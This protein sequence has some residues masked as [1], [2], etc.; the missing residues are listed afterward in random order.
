[1]SSIPKRLTPREIKLL[2]QQ[3]RRNSFS[4]SGSASLLGNEGMKYATNKRSSLCAAK[5]DAST[6]GE[7]MLENEENIDP[8]NSLAGF[9]DENRRKKPRVDSNNKAKSVFGVRN[10]ARASVGSSNAS[11]KGKTASLAPA[12]GNNKKRKTWHNPLQNNGCESG[13]GNSVGGGIKTRSKSTHDGKM[14]KIGD[15]F[16]A[17]NSAVTGVSAT[18][19]TAYTNAEPDIGLVVENDESQISESQSEKKKK[20]I[21][22]EDDDEEDEEFVSNSDTES[23]CFGLDSNA[24]RDSQVATCSRALVRHLSNLSSLSQKAPFETSSLVE[25]VLANNSNKNA[26]GATIGSE[27]RRYDDIDT[28][29]TKRKKEEGSDDESY[30]TFEDID[31][32][33]YDWGFKSTARF[34]S[35]DSFN[36]CSNIKS[37]FKAQAVQDKVKHMTSWEEAS[38]DDK[39]KLFYQSMMCWG[40]S[41]DDEALMYSALHDGIKK[42]NKG[43]S[44]TKYVSKSATLVSNICEDHYFTAITSAYDLFKNGKISHF[45]V[46]S[47]YFTTLFISDETGA[48]DGYYAI[49]NSSSKGL[50]T[51]LNKEEISY[52]LPLLKPVEAS[53][54]ENAVDDELTDEERAL[55]HLEARFEKSRQMSHE[56]ALLFEGLEEVHGLFDFMLNRNYLAAVRSGRYKKSQNGSSHNGTFFCPDFPNIYCPAPFVNGSLRSLNIKYNGSVK[57]SKGGKGL[58]QTNIFEINGP[59]LFSSLKA[60]LKIFAISQPSGFEV[61]LK[62]EKDLINSHLD[63]SQSHTIANRENKSRQV[64]KQ[65]S[66]ISGVIDRLQAFSL[67][68]KKLRIANHDNVILDNDDDDSLLPPMPGSPD[69]LSHTSNRSQRPLAQSDAAKPKT[70]LTQIK[71]S[72]GTFRCKYL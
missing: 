28:S 56:T 47:N 26:L 53:K 20:R 58:D 40:Y 25:D 1:M 60:L 31:D 37:S 54:D 51:L 43:K 63:V 13:D 27:E 21:P 55:K 66:K 72:G 44:N 49:I 42:Q 70:Q 15:K 35:K 71:Y 46:D 69:L 14:K 64:Q 24:S 7:G 30:L 23:D 34:S 65:A 45:Y 9:K 59:I 50:R 11:G 12:L 67:I 8:N 39:Q 38:A 62:S 18:T 52:S 19:E 48:A 6:N 29:I 10:D 57:V 3:R 32:A 41:G 22:E 17:L 5:D 33:P 68:V 36:W 61:V 16:L 4:A 2:Q